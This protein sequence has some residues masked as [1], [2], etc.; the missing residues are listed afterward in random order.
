MMP[1]LSNV[2]YS[3]HEVSHGPP[4]RAC[5][6]PQSTP[7][8]GGARERTKGKGKERE[9]ERA[10]L[11]HLDKALP[12]AWDVFGGGVYL[13]SASTSS[14]VATAKPGFSSTVGSTSSISPTAAE[15]DPVSTSAPTAVTAKPDPSPSLIPCADFGRGDG[16]SRSTSPTPRSPSQTLSEAAPTSSCSVYVGGSPLAPQTLLYL[17][18]CTLTSLPLPLRQDLSHKNTNSSPKASSHTSNPL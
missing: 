1:A 9:T 12:R 2:S 6:L 3:V 10:S 11:G 17:Y 15:P 14:V 18:L 4:A 8:R 5:P 7:A 16:D 13:G